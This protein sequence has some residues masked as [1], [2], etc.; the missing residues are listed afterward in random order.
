ML[1]YSST[2]VVNFNI[3]KYYLN[4]LI[5]FSK[6]IK[7]SINTDRLV[8]S[9]FNIFT[10]IWCRHIF[11]CMSLISEICC[12]PK[13]SLFCARRSSDWGALGI[14]YFYL[15]HLITHLTKSWINSKL[16][17]PSK[18]S[19]VWAGSTMCPWISRLNDRKLLKSWCKNPPLNN[20]TQ[21]LYVTGGGVG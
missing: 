19:V 13:S 20:S 17:A 6:N 1:R 18:K 11:L 15:L 3:R 9:R 8:L 4:C 14:Y 21:V 7:C 5:F 12:H 2:S 10:W 16:R